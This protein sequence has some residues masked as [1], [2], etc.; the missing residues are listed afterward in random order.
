MLVG[1]FLDLPLDIGDNPKTAVHPWI[2]VHPEFAIDKDIDNKL[3]IS[4]SP[5]GFLGRIS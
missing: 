2:S 4:V 1:S 3:L 5:D